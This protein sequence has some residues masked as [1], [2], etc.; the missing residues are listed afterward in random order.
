MTTDLLAFSVRLRKLREAT[1]LKQTDM[2]EM[3]NISFMQYYRYEHGKSFPRYA[4]LI[5]LADY[6]NVSLD[7][8]CGRDTNQSN[9]STK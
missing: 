9:R 2:C 5:A 1:N 6:F 4:D 3:L 8:L 7:Y